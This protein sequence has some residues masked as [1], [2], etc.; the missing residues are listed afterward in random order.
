[1][2]G[3]TL[4]YT[5]EDDGVWIEHTSGW[6]KNL[7]FSPTVAEVLQAVLDHEHGIG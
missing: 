4:T 2:T 1:M 3:Y 7:G 6:K 5:N